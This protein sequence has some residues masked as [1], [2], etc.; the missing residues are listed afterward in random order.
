VNHRITY[1]TFALALIIGALFGLQTQLAYADTTT[2]SA[3]APY[4]KQ[5][6]A[7]GSRGSEVVKLQQILNRYNGENITVTGYYGRQTEAAVKRFQHK[8]G[9]TTSGKQLILTTARIN[10]LHCG[11]G[12]QNMGI[13]PIE[14]S[15]TTACPIYLH[16]YAKVGTSSSDV[17]RL[18]TFLN[19]YYDAQI[20]VTGYFGRITESAVRQFQ[21]EY[22]IVPRSGMQLQETTATINRLY[23]M[24]GGISPIANPKPVLY[25]PVSSHQ[26]KTSVNPPIKNVVVD[27]V[28]RVVK[29][30]ATGTANKW[31]TI[32]VWNSLEGGIVQKAF[33]R[34]ANLLPDMPMRSALLNIAILI[35]GLIIIRWLWMMLVQAPTNN[36]AQLP[37]ILPPAQKDITEAES[38]ADHTNKESVGE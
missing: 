10:A 15:T 27:S 29:K 1:S 7:R 23:C 28:Q 9:I 31:K 32:D 11:F 21:D 26:Q 3:C 20:P 6:N 13:L 33:E 19:V 24:F 37:L 4:I 5:Y 30:S 17:A 18:Q 34:N 35:A 12:S 16:Q 38:T 22:G 14:K 8:Y 36:Y 2:S 25:I